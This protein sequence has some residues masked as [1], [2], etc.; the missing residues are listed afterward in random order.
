[1]SCRLVG[2]IGIPLP[3]P[4]SPVPPD[5]PPPSKCYSPAKCFLLCRSDEYANSILTLASMSGLICSICS[6]VNFPKGQGLG[7]HPRNGRPPRPRPRPCHS[8]PNF[9]RP[10]FSLRSWN[11]FIC[12]S[13]A[14]RA[15]TCL[16]SIPL[17]SLGPGVGDIHSFPP[18]SPWWKSGG[19]V[20]LLKKLNRPIVCI[21]CCERC[22]LVLS[23]LG[24]KILLV[25]FSEVQQAV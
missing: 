13:S 6:A 1:M 11:S 10:S 17:G 16:R 12:A 8:S 7:S 23:T 2:R 15:S 3:A 21:V 4:G 18:G 22:W 20:S 5:S 19:G 9:P 24:H 25:R 14:T